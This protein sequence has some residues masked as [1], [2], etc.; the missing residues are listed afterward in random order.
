[1]LFLILNNHCG[2][3][4]V[5]VTLC[6]LK[7]DVFIAY[8]LNIELY[9]EVNLE[10]PSLASDI[11][12]LNSIYSCQKLSCNVLKCSSS[13]WA[14]WVSS[15]HDILHGLAWN[16]RLQINKDSCMRFLFSRLSVF[17]LVGSFRWVNQT[18][19]YFQ[20]AGISLKQ[21]IVKHKT[22]NTVI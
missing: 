22:L 13:I 2:C 1:M 20:T 18:S 8:F 21:W 11:H 10:T 4:C 9:M 12:G 14:Q 16:N 15:P 19:K 7:L 3:C 5:L 17:F 6:K